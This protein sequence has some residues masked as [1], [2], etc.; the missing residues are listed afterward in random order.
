MHSA[1]LEPDAAGIFVGSSY[2]YATGR[3]WARLGLLYLQD[4]V[5]QGRRLLPEAW[6][7][8]SVTPVP[9]APEGRYGAQIWLKLDQGPAAKSPDVGEPPFPE[10]AYY[11]LGHYGQTVA[12]VPS[13]NLVIVRLGQTWD[14]GDWDPAPVL[15]PIVNAFPPRT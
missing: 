9:A 14:E 12:I 2:L 7:A 11:M 8:Y 4:G 10:D 5:W 3:D 6:V 13:R 1:V 15:A